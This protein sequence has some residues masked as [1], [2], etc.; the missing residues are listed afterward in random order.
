MTM[1][2]TREQV[3]QWA[4]EYADAWAAN[5]RK[6]F[7]GYVAEHTA[8]EVRKG[9]KYLKIVDVSSDASVVAFVD[10]TTGDVYKP[11]GW[12]RPAKG[13]RARLADKASREALFASH[14]AGSM[15]LYR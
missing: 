6:A 3:A 5:T 11:D 15:G 8:S 14:F 4:Q 7:G 1:T 9:R 12:S 13:V 2:V 10:A